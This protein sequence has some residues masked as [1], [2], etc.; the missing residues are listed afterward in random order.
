M[1]TVLPEQKTL[2]VDKCKVKHMGKINFNCK[3]IERGSKLASISQ[4]L[5]W[6]QYE[7]L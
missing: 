4:K 1:V 2:S 6:D 7:F 3:Y 5:S